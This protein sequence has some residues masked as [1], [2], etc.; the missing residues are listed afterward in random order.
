MKELITSVVELAQANTLTFAIAVFMVTFAVFIGTSPSFAFDAKGRAKPFG[1]GIKRRTVTPVWLVAII[2][3]IL[4]YTA[5]L[6]LSNI[7]S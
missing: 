2:I 5:V 6:Y 4:S 3:A 7:T 1:I